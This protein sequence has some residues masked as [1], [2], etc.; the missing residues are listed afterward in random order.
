MAGKFDAFRA[1]VKHH[2]G[3]IGVAISGGLD[4]TVVL[5][6]L[7]EKNHPGQISAYC[8]K[9]GKEDSEFNAAQEVARNY[10]V[11]FFSWDFNPKDYWDSLA[12]C[13][14]FFDRPRWNIWPYILMKM[15]RQTKMDFHEEII[16]GSGCRYFYIGEGSDETFGYQDRSYLKGWISQLEYI[17]PV[18]K[19]GSDHLGLELHAP[20]LEVET[21]IDGIG[22]P[23]S[24]GFFCGRYKYD[25]WEEY[26][27][28][29]KGTVIYPKKALVHY[30]SIL[31][32]TKQ[33]LQLEATK[34]WLEART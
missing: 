21:N 7:C 33:E 2:D 27:K 18:W 14:A 4:S 32:K 24:L 11:R 8:L 17:F 5:H 23:S 34:L 10:G 20:F 6:E 19:Q 1:N 16:E 12:E 22:L 25:L 9:Q 3:N 26:E 31:Q 29:L 15:A 28:K 13:M 30:Y